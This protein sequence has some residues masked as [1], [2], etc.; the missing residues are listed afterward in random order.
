MIHASGRGYMAD[1]LVNKEIYVLR[2]LAHT[3]SRP[4]ACKSFLVSAGTFRTIHLAVLMSTVDRSKVTEFH[5]WITPDC[6]PIFLPVSGSHGMRKG[7]PRRLC[8]YVNCLPDGYISSHED[9]VYDEAYYEA[10]EDCT[11]ALS[12]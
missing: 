1:G 8:G 2:W 4:P 12:L 5:D 9:T 3:S 6:L 11:W 10:Y 7:G